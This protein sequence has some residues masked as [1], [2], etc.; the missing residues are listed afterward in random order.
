MTEQTPEVTTNTALELAAIPESANNAEPLSGMAGNRA[1]VPP[2]APII[3]ND[4]PSLNPL[5]MKE[6][7]FIENYLTNGYV[8][9]QACKDSGYKCSTD[10]GFRV[11]ASQL[12]RKP[13]VKRVLDIRREEVETKLKANTEIT[14]ELVLERLHALAVMTMEKTAIKQEGKTIVL[15]QPQAS[16][17]CWELLGKEIGM[18]IDRTADV[19]ETLT[20][21]TKQ[22][23]I[24]KQARAMVEQGKHSKSTMEQGKEQ[25]GVTELAE[26]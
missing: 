20:E 4:N 6:K 25:A 3:T 24:L 9:S 10:E 5:T 15:Y 18:F 14:R 2:L 11:K 22:L 23:A 8:G 7:T 16:A 13:N 19:S 1:E 12:L 21:R 26:G 17:R